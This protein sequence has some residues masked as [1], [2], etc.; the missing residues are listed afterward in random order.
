MTYTRKVY[1]I[2]G[3][4]NVETFFDVMCNDR[5]KLS[6][7]KDSIDISEFDSE[8]E[9]E[10]FRLGLCKVNGKNST[11]FCEITEDNFRKLKKRFK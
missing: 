1:L 6:N 2:I 3:E 4:E 8:A 7:L 11:D 9:E 5:G 10:A